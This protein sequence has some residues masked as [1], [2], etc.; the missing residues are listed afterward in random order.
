MT[1]VGISD[2]VVR[3]IRPRQDPVDSSVCSVRCQR[4]SSAHLLPGQS[5]PAWP[6]DVYRMCSDVSGAL[7]SGEGR[8]LEA[9]PAM[10]GPAGGTLENCGESQLKRGPA[11]CK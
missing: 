10:Q 2:Q 1:S 11:Q 7:S 3:R 9:A 5:A 6:P 8:V 4:T